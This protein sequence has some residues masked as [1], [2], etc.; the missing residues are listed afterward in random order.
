MI[1]LALK[2][3]WF[4]TLSTIGELY[5]DGAREC[6]VLEDRYRAP[7]EKK[8][9]HETCVPVGIFEVIWAWSPRFQRFTLRLVDV[10]E[11]SGVLI[12]GG[13]RP[14]D[15]DGCLLT[16]RTRQENYVGESQLALRALEAKVIPRLQA[17]E[18]CQ[19]AITVE[20]H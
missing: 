1:D 5:V 20:P 14:A 6:F 15:T 12:H 19:L 18:K 4:T 2:R 11:F 8:V 3:R 13:N 7:P 9:P 10:P 17:G 16:G